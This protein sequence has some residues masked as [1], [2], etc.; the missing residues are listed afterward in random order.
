PEGPG[1]A[2]AG[3]RAVPKPGARALVPIDRLRPGL[4]VCPSREA[5][6]RDA[7]P[8][9][10]AG[11]GHGAGN[12]GRP[13]AAKRVAR[14]GLP[15]WR[16]AHRRRNVPRDGYAVLAGEGGAGVSRLT[17]AL[18]GRDARAEIGL[19]SMSR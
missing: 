10:D 17:L 4:C 16:A 8:R 9:A 6:R 11:T 12:H 19:E 15:A 2:R 3:A 13:F 5:R 18:S 7:P 14:R 1:G